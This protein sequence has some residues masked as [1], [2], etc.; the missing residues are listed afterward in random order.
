MHDLRQGWIAHPFSIPRPLRRWLSD[1]GSLT[2]RLRSRCHDFRV[3]PH[4]TGCA[5]PHAD[6]FAQLDLAA[7]VRTYV[8][9]VSL[10]CGDTPM[11]FAHSVLPLTGLRGG[12]THITRIGNRSLGEALFR[13]R[14]IARQPL[15]FRCVR[16][17]HP[18]HRAAAARLPV[19]P[20]RLWARRSV[21]CLNGHPLLVT[22]V[23]LPAIET[24][25]P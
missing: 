17:G 9:E 6:E 7:G 11:V 12:W 13:N 2:Q 10:M 15:A 19:A 5:R 8:R 4:A 18:L 24:L 25:C 21:F 22:E 1:R 16:R 23:F 3:V 14:R 20:Q